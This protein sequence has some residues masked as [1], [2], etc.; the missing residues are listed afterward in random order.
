MGKD[1]VINEVEGAIIRVCT[2]IKEKKGG[3]GADKLDSLSKLINSYNRLLDK[4]NSSE[5]D[6]N[7]D[8][9]PEYY[10]QLEKQERVKRHV[11][12]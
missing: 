4:S 5:Y 1:K 12:R 7:E 3:S 9:D 8:G 10:K 6:A 11:V 2:D